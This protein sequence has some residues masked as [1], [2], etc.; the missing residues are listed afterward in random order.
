MAAQTITGFWRISNLLTAVLFITAIWLP[1]IDQLFGI[2]PMPKGEENR[3]LADYPDFN[4]SIDFFN[5]YPG[6]FESYYNDHFGFR[7][8][9]IAMHT[10]AKTRLFGISGSDSVIL[11][12]D[13]W[14]FLGGQA[15][16]ESYRYLRP[17]S[18][19]QLDRWTRMLLARR[20]LLKKK[21][22]R[23]LV[24][25]AP[26]KQT[27]HPEMMPN[28]IN[29]VGEQ[30]RID[31]LVTHLSDHTDLDVIDLRTILLGAKNLFDPYQKSDTHWSH[32]GRYAAY[33]AVVHKIGEWDPRIRPLKLNE[34]SW[35]HLVKTGGDLANMMGF[36]PFIEERMYHFTPKNGYKAETKP[37]EGMLKEFAWNNT[38]KP[39]LFERKD[40]TDLPR[41][42]MVGDSF[43]QSFFPIIAEHF[44]QCVFV[45]HS[46]DPA[47]IEELDPDIVVFQAVERFL[48]IDLPKN[49]ERILNIHNIDRSIQ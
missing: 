28:H 3:K 11:G 26:N 25:L 41:L 17:F 15:F 27:I 12:K 9:L 5:Q 13:G 37:L 16:I 2:D 21:G 32:I 43:G 8:S 46:F 48:L 29:K 33:F 44:S 30:T 18:E 14:L 20:D 49:S 7:T 45:F 19:E 39:M 34:L 47:L 6:L 42:L 1:I 22:S 38:R 40:A 4:Y 10:L 23:F 35:R 31:Q 24:L 36:A